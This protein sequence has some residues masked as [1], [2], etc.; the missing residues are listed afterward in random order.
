MDESDWRNGKDPQPL[1]D[2]LHQQGR[3]SE[4]KARLFAVGCCR[5]IWHL[6]TDER[7]RTAVEV[8]ERHAG[9]LAGSPELAGVA[10]YAERAADQSVDA[11]HDFEVSDASWGPAL[12]ASEAALAA[13]FA[14]IFT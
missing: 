2:W 7:S 8:A 13:R 3:L 1:L 11:L 6:L 14:S 9:G 5:R 10:A 12:A 4:R